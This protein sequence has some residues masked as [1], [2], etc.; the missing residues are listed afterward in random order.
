MASMAEPE[1][2]RLL[3][4]KTME[5]NDGLVKINHEST[6]AIPTILSAIWGITS[7]ID[8]TNKVNTLPFLAIISIFILLTWRC[9]AHY[10]DNDVA[11]NYSRIMQFEKKLEVPQE[12]SIFIG[13]I[14]GLVKNFNNENLRLEINNL[15][16]N[17]R[18]ELINQ[19]HQK[20]QLGYRGHFWWDIFALLIIDIS[21]A[22]FLQGFFVILIVI[23]PISLICYKLSVAHLD[24]QIDPT[25]SEFIES[26]NVAKKILPKNDNH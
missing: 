11:S 17:Q 10:I 7:Y 2:L 16:E 15:C 24:F 12:C 4:Q 18:I 9:F 26:L 1:T 8:A 25:E 3:L 13:L 20:N 6:I 14:R 23:I 21:V 19:L 5:R 22:I